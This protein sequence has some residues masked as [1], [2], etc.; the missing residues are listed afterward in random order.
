MKLSLTVIGVTDCHWRYLLCHWCYMMLILPHS[1]LTSLNSFYMVHEDVGVSFPCMIN[2]LL[3]VL[4][5]LY[6]Y[7][8][9][10]THFRQH[11][12]FY[13]KSSINVSQDTIQTETNV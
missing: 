2:F 1:F 13:N 5:F 11:T 6:T 4:A 3:K 9:T 10:G 12:V 8:Y 7:N